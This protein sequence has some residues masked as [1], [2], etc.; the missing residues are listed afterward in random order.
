MNNVVDGF[1]HQFT[2]GVLEELAHILADKFNVTIRVQCEHEAIDGIEQEVA[3]VI[4]QY[5]WA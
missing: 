3:Y 5:A 1:V 2:L 4:R